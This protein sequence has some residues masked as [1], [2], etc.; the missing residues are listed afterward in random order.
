MIGF[1]TEGNAYKTKSYLYFLIIDR[2]S[3]TQILN[4]INYDSD[5]DFKLE[6][7]ISLLLKPI[8]S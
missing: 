5:D 2:K 6:Y 1:C 3:E 4:I 7:I 8:I